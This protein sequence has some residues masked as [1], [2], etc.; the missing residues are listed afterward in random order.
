M[1]K[2][3]LTKVA[4]ATVLVIYSTGCGAPSSDNEAEETATTEE[5]AVNDEDDF[6]DPT[7]VADA[8]YTLLSTEGNIRIVEMVLEP[9]QTDNI[10][11]HKNETVY[12][13]TGG[14]A[15]I[16]VG[17]EV[18]EADVPD[19]HIMH[20]GPWTHSVENVGETTIRAIIFEQMEME[21]TAEFADYI[22]ATE[23]SSENYKLL[24]AEGNVRVVSMMLAPG[25]TDTEHSHR[26]E[27][28]YFLTGG[29]LKI[30]VG[31]EVMEAEIPD[32]HVMHHPAWTHHVENVGETPVH[33]IIFERM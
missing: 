24:S 7:V 27:T 13:I 19:G 20:H 28:G 17:D 16:H 21:E 4:L 25:E 33:A 9:G 30:Y 26:A 11:S 32:G 10:H 23:A 6:L 5:E 3:I 22:D 14:Q 8:N 2:S 1:K 15:K 29:K 31:E 18:M 12:F